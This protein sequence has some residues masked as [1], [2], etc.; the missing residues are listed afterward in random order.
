MNIFS[1]LSSILTTKQRIELDTESE[2]EFNLYMVNR[3]LSMYSPDVA[4]LVNST[5]NQ[6]WSIF[7]SKQEQYDF[8]FNLLGKNK[9]KKINYIKKAAKTKKKSKSEEEDL[10]IMFA[11]A[12]FMS[13]K[14]LRELQNDALL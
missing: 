13:L 11:N 7:E 9:F 2:K 1:I 10:D 6:W 8:L 4:T 12:N 5:T 14:Q 3:W